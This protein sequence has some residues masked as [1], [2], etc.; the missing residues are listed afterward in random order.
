MSISRVLATVLQRE[1]HGEA[2]QH[3]DPPKQYFSHMAKP[4]PVR[5]AAIE[6]IREKQ[7]FCMSEEVR[8]H[9]T[10]SSKTF[11]IGKQ[12]EFIHNVTPQ[13]LGK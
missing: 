10:P 8:F 7:R 2:A 3:F 4:Q 6:E 11:P 12:H 5:R 13:T 1:Q 9:T